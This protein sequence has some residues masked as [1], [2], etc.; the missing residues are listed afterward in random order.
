MNAQRLHSLDALRG[1][2]LLLGFVV[3]ASLAYVPGMPAIAWPVLD[4]ART[5]VAAVAFFA[6]HQFRMVLFFVIAGF[7][8]HMLL[9][10]R[11]LRGFWANRGKRIALPLVLG[12]MVFF[13]LTLA[14]IAWGAAHAGAALAAPAGLPTLPLGFFPF[15][16]LWFLYYLLVFYAAATVLRAIARVLDPAGRVMRG[17]DWVVTGIVKS[18]CLAVLLGVPAA[19]VLYQ[20]P[21]WAPWVGIPAPEYSVIPQ[22]PA[23]A[24][25]GTAFAVGWLLH[26]QADLLSLIEKQGEAYLLAGIVLTTVCLGWG[27]VSL[28]ATANPFQGLP[29]LGIALAYAAGAWAWSFGLL[30]LALRYLSKESPARRYLADASYWI[31]LSHLPLVFIFEGLAAPLSWPWEIKLPLVM[32]ATFAVTLVTYHYWVRRTVLGVLLNGRKIPRQAPRGSTVPAVP[33]PSASSNAPLAG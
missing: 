8:A 25:Y 12:W 24:G 1:L 3:H 11:G 4:H 15:S 29:K 16:Y 21:G 17:A 26:R 28:A 5:P 27:G 2:A 19:W 14:A 13:P 18:R 32:S 33:A 31:Y 9:Q 6:S 23:V 20:V 30:G 7:F 10:K 22:L